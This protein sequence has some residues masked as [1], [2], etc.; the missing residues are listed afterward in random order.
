MAIKL[1]C[2]NNGYPDFWGSL[3]V[4]PPGIRP[5]D[6]AFINVQEYGTEILA[7]IEQNN[8]A[9]PTGHIRQVA[10]IEVPEFC[11]SSR[12]LLASDE[13]GYTYYS[14]R[15]KGEL[16]RKYER[17]YIA[18]RRLTKDSDTFRYTDYSGWRYLEDSSDYLPLWIVAEDSTMHRR[19]TIIHNGAMLKL[20]T[21]YYDES[22]NDLSHTLQNIYCRTKEELYT[23][24]LEIFQKKK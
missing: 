1:Y 13:P 24:L 11:F 5:L 2:G 16:G 6:C 12:I 17:L 8:L 7:W 19:C 9:K 21:A 10:D 3:T 18:L 22:G 4:N 15:Q 23:H 20:T 14:R